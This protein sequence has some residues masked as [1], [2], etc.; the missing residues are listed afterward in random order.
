MRG[1]GVVLL[2]RICMMLDLLKCLVYRLIYPLGVSDS[3]ENHF[4]L[5]T[6]EYLRG[7]GGEIYIHVYVFTIF[8]TPLIS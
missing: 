5:Y 2:P 7:L 1:V 6:T 3:H 4:S 8:I